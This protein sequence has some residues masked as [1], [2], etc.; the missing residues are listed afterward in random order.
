MKP[1]TTH[2]PAEPARKLEAEIHASLAAEK[3][4]SSETANA[5]AARQPALEQKFL[6]LNQLSAGIAH[7]FNNVIAGIL[8]SAELIAMDLPA[9]HPAHESLRQI[10]EASNRAR[11]FLQKIRALAQRPPVSRQPVPLQPVIEECLQIL[12]GIIPAKVELESEINPGCPPVNADAAQIHQALLDL[13]LYCWHGLPE[14]SG[15]IKVTLENCR[16]TKNF[17]PALHSGPHVRLTVRDNSPGLDHRARE[18]IFD[19]FHTRKAAAKKIGLELFLVRELV[20]AHHGE[21]T[22]ESE[23]GSGLAFHIY[24]PV[25]V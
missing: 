8:G 2:T 22:V 3:N 18:K 1:A 21:I 19:P 16:L 23:P 4:L 12:R 7:E 13:C 20:H 5:D 10:F 17:S 15:H 25:A 9:D 11:D 14:R 6:A 24:L